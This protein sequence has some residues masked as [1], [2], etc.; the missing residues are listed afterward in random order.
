[1]AN[2]KYEY[3]DDFKRGLHKGDDFY[4]TFKDKF[5][6]GR[7]ASVSFTDYDLWYTVD[8]LLRMFKDLEIKIIIVNTMGVAFKGFVYGLRNDFKETL[9]G[10]YD[11]VE[12]TENQV[13]Y[14]RQEWCS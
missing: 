4:D 8:S 7:V 13:C 5:Y 9:N 10:Y 12:T 2:V 3:F 6:T 14:I 11:L 1:M